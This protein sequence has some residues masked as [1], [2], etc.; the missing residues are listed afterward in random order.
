MIKHKPAI[1]TTVRPRQT[2]EKKCPRDLSPSTEVPEDEPDI[3][4]CA[5]HETKHE[6]DKVPRSASPT[7]E[8]E[9]SNCL[10]N[11]N[12][13]EILEESI[14]SLKEELLQQKA[15]TDLIL[16]SHTASDKKLEQFMK[17]KIAPLEGRIHQL[18][19]DLNTLR[20]TVN[21]QNNMLATLTERCSSKPRDAPS[22]KSLHQ[23]SEESCKRRIEKLETGQ[24]NIIEAMRTL[25]NK[26]F[27]TTPHGH[28]PEY[29][30]AKQADSTP[31]LITS[32][33]H[34]ICDA[35]K[36]NKH[37][38]ETLEMGQENVV[39]ALRTLS[40]K[41]SALNTNSNTV[42][43]SQTACSPAEQTTND[44][45]GENEACKG[46]MVT[47]SRKGDFTNLS[48]TRNWAQ[49]VENAENRDFTAANKKNAKN[50]NDAKKPRSDHSGQQERTQE[51]G[52]QSRNRD[53]PESA[54][55]STSGSSA[56]RTSR[57]DTTNTSRYK[58]HTALLIHDE[59]FD[60]FNS[61]EFNKQFNVHKFGATSFHDLEK[62]S[63]Q[64]NSTLKRLKPDCVYIHLGINDLLTKKS[65]ATG[66]VHELADHLLNTTSAQICFSLLIPSSNDKK[67]NDRIRIFNNEIK[68][69]VSWFHKQSESNRS[70]IFTFTN[71][72]VGDQNSYSPNTGCKLGERGQKMLYIRLREGL[73]KTMR[74]PRQSH[75]SDSNRRRSSNRYSHE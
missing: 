8:T 1:T 68:S 65:S 40:S 38:I 73:R 28:N 22:S 43:R 49:V 56:N 14:L 20:D 7:Q 13:L 4:R 51:R 36:S 60:D 53:A 69:N 45:K 52:H 61:K 75:H 59:N 18:R 34:E 12:S 10:T 24:E 42:A 67:L 9:C 27:S 50:H 72:N 66:S 46:E 64:L 29:S 5:R 6:T 3:L 17:G 30:L 54:K 31:E 70:R 16:S 25:S 41:V 15:T 33:T 35:T 48:E 32:A 58:R 63:K 2:S 55:T 21:E 71:D 62:K 37:R 19:S 44:L 23:T 74:L 47:G 57:D 39:A 26:V 11:S